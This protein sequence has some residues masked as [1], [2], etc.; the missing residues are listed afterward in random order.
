MGETSLTDSIGSR[1]SRLSHSRS[2]KQHPSGACRVAATGFFQ[3]QAVQE[4]EVR[5][6]RLHEP[7]KWSAPCVRWRCFL[8]NVLACI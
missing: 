1:I 5:L 8:A 2:A 7:S 4:L 3:L 6:N